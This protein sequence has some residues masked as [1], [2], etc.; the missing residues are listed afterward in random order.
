MAPIMVALAGCAAEPA[1]DDDPALPPGAQALLTYGD[2]TPALVAGGIGSGQLLLA[3]FSP[4][5]SISDLGKH[6][7]FVAL[8]QVLARQL[9][10]PSG[11]Q[12]RPTVGE[13]VRL[14]KTYPITAGAGMVVAGPDGKGVPS[15]T[16]I[17]GDQI[18]LQI[19]RPTL[20]GFYQVRRGSELVDTVAIGVDPRESDLARVQRTELLARLDAAGVQ[21]DLRE[22]DDWDP[23]VE[24]RGQQ[25]WGWFVLAAMC[26]MGL[27]LLCLG[28]W[29]R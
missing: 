20:P 15:S 16:N 12:T 23:L 24:M 2:G 28:I 7:S 6:G 5:L 22:M 3:N 10:R 18:A 17:I 11:G 13:P 4:A 9:R 14:A 21:L 26:A 29:K 27:E 8:V 19:E 1:S 25:V